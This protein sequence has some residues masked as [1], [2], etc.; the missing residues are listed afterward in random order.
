MRINWIGIYG[1]LFTNNSFTVSTILNSPP[2]RV[3]LAN[4]PER[5]RSH[6][7]GLRI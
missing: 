2:M 4:D 5:S 3:S 7:V 1:K 6:L